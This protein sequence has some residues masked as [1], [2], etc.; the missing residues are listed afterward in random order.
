MA[1][2][3]KTLREKMSNGL[4]TLGDGLKKLAKWA[5]WLN[6]QLAFQNCGAGHRLSSRACLA[7]DFGGGCISC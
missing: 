6:R 2:N 7:L 3:L 1:N 5:D 4:K